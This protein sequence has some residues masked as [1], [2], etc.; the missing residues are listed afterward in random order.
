MAISKRSSN[1]K[2]SERRIKKRHRSSSPVRVIVD[3]ER[4]AIDRG[5]LKDVSRNGMRIL[6]DQS[7]E[8]EQRIQI[9]IE[10]EFNVVRQSTARVM[11]CKTVESGLF[12][13]GCQLELRLAVAQYVLLCDFAKTEE[14]A[15]TVG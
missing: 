15:E 10:D 1:A 6:I 4:H 8:T 5:E 14:L 2:N 3:G 13:V 12:Q 7:L 9:E 11:W